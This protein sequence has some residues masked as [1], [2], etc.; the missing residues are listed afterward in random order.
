M[1]T[2]SPGELGP[3][4]GERDRI[5]AAFIGLVGERG[6]AGLDTVE[7]CKRARVDPAA[8]DRHFEDTFECF[9]L[10]WDG[11]EGAFLERLESCRRGN[12]R[13]SD[14]LRA[15]LAE[16]ARLVEAHPVPARFLSI[17][18]LDAPEPVR[19]KAAALARRLRE[20]LDTALGQGEDPTVVPEATSRWLLAVFFDRIYR[21]LS[22]TDRGD[23]TAQLPQ[24]M[25]LAVSAY[26]GREAGLEELRA[27]PPE[28]GRSARP[29]A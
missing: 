13:W 5:V 28:R 20:L 14:Q 23:L 8:F 6:Y 1:R 11:L 22:G 17:S 27:Q 18:A 24:L 3:A 15:C 2:L 12:D 29:D 16:T 21:H 9:A 10:A 7:V 26:F 25:F 4:G 19:A